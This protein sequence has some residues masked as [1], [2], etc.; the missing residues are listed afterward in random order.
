[1]GS[2]QRLLD[3]AA[4]DN[5]IELEYTD[6]FGHIHHAS[7]EITRALLGV[8]RVA[9]ATDADLEQAL[10]SEQAA[11]ESR[12]IDPVI[13]VRDDHQAILLRVPKSIAGAT[14]KLELEWEGGE[15]EHHWYWLPELPPWDQSQN[16]PLQNSDAPMLAKRLPLPKLRLGYHKL[17]VLKLPVG[18]R[19]PDGDQSLDGLATLAGARF[20]VCPPRA[21]T[22]DR[23]YAGFGVSLYGVRS[24]R[25][26]GCGD[27]TD[28]HAII[29][30]LAPAGAAFIGLNPL[31]AIANRQPYNTSPYLP[32]CALYRNFIYL[33]VERVSAAALNKD[34]ASHEIAWTDEERAE[35]AALRATREFLLEYERV[36]QLKLAT[37]SEIFQH[38]PASDDFERVSSPSR[39]SRWP[40][41]PFTARSTR[42]CA[43]AIPPSGCGP[44]GPTIITSP[45]PS[46]AVAEFAGEHRQRVR[47]FQFL[48]WQLS[49]QAA[50]A[51]AH[52]KRAGMEIGIYHDLALATDRY[53]ADLWANRPFY[54]T[55]CRVGAPPDDLAPQGQDWGFP[56]P[57]RDAHR[58]DSYH[59]FAQ[60]AIRQPRTPEGALRIDHV[61][62]FFRL[63]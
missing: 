53:G 52:A 14:I 61:M 24:A 34:A 50:E 5:G 38:F 17:R 42:R 25:N 36:A 7:D 51:Q 32:E 20:I 37:L 1:M 12:I 57:C 2:D 62:R 11:R 58:R 55:G 54:S 23:R 56:P 60:S 27:F 29:D 8:L 13:V 6:V 44:N 46:Q 22:V 45:L 18:V 28:L 10:A 41:T 48:Q 63:F 31:H 19:K 16:S 33:D 59:L 39:A 26:W 35:I 40:I 30:A 47:F 9:A 3:R 49:V 15:L 43:A 4:A 21:K